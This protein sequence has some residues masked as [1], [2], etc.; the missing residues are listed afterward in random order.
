M[1]MIVLAA[2]TFPIVGEKEKKVRGRANPQPLTLPG[3]Y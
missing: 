2:T 1:G 3:A